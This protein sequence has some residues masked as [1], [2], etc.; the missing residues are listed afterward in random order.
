MSP[1]IYQTILSDL[2][3]PLWVTYCQRVPQAL[4][5]YHL[6]EGHNKRVIHDHISLRTV[7]LP[8]TSSSVLTEQLEQFGYCIRDR[9]S[10]PKDHLELYWLHHPALE[11][12]AILITELDVHCLSQPSQSIMTQI[13]SESSNPAHWSLDQTP[14]HKPTLQQFET[15]QSDNEIAAWFSLFGTSAHYFSVS[16]NHLGRQNDMLKLVKLLMEEGFA[17]DNRSGLIRESAHQMIEQVI[18][19][20]DQME[21]NFGSQE[22]ARVSTGCYHFTLRFKNPSGKLYKKFFSCTK[23]D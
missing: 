2:I 3:T 14:P 20:P 8:W 11:V 17:L 15:L 22:K 21:V 19:L 16:V 10:C 6:L 12:P 5:I 9:A 13:T 4:K 7:N 18:S 1:T 23:A